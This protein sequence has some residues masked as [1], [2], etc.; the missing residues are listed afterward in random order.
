MSVCPCCSHILVRQVSGHKIYW[1]CPVCWQPMPNFSELLKS[2]EFLTELT[3][4][5]EYTELGKIS[6]A[7]LL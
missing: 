6:S 5:D 1:F 3:K 7:P 4:S 2:N